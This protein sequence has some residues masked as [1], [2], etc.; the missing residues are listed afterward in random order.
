MFAWIS[1]DD[2]IVHRRGG[3]RSA[4]QQRHQHHRGDGDCAVARA[5]MALALGTAFGDL[6]LLRSAILTALAG[7]VRRWRCP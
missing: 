6:A 5:N 7:L 1:G 3:H 2:G 4:P